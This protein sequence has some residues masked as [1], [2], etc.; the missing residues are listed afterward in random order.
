VEKH[1]FCVFSF[2]S[3]ERVL[4]LAVT[5][6]S[7]SV[8]LLGVIGCRCLRGIDCRRPEVDGYTVGER[9]WK[10]VIFC[11]FSF[12]AMEWGFEAYGLGE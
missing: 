7:I 11:V 2:A 6:S 5:G 12:A 3:M 10:N 9:S 1:A 8:R 4:R